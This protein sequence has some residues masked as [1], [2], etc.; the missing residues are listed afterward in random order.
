MENTKMEEKN[1]EILETQHF[2]TDK[3][4]KYSLNIKDIIVTQTITFETAEK[5]PSQYA[6]LIEAKEKRLKEAISKDSIDEAK[7]TINNETKEKRISEAIAEE[8]LNG[9][10][11]KTTQSMCFFKNILVNPKVVS[12]GN[13]QEQQEPQQQP[14]PSQKPQHV[15]QPSE[16]AQ[17]QRRKPTKRTIRNVNDDDI[18][19]E[20][21]KAPK[22]ARILNVKSFTE[23]QRSGGD[24]KQFIRYLISSNIGEVV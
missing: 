9:A 12:S 22:R 6:R 11:K 1:V 10:T 21:V 20:K 14:Q 8:R 2:D 19:Q 5:E 16:Q 3:K 17:Q 24:D 4:K 18:T 7:E 13:K 15:Q 23:H